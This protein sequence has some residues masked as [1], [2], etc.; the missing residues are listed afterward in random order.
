MKEPKPKSGNSAHDVVILG[1][2]PAGLTAGIYAR[3]ARLDTILMEK[4]AP[5]GLAA[6]TDKIDNYPGF[7]DG[8][9]GAE[10]MARMESQARGLG[11]EIVSG[12]VRSVRLE[13][14]EKEVA[15]D[16]RSY[17]GKVVIIATGT[18]P[19]K[20][21]VPGEDGLRG[22]GVSYCATCDGPLFRDRD[23][24]VVG[25]GDSGI[26]EGLFLL[27]FAKS[28][29]FVEF[30]PHMTAE[31]ILQ[32]RARSEPRMKF[33]LGHLVTSVNGTDTVESVTVQNRESGEEKVIEAQGVFIYVGM[34]PNT[35]FL[36]RKVRLD[37]KNYVVTDENLQTSVPGVFGCGDVRQ[38]TLRQVATAV[39]DGALAAFMA[40]SYLTAVQGG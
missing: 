36:K 31:K 5:G 20:L 22:R 24:V 6:T 15:T 28:I 38:K 13:G 2:G 21:G 26:Q 37:E 23:L 12:E 25:C 8:I 29:T 14:D 16:E 27:R 9:G 30:L 32:E 1:G 4:L 18:E 7:P 19:R 40:D 35:Q 3:R 39:G 17:S 10:L 33:H 11:L 34:D